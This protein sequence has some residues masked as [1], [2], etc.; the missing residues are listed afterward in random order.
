MTTNDMQYFTGRSGHTSWWRVIKQTTD[1]ALGV[2][3]NK[4]FIVIIK[5]ALPCILVIISTP[6]VSRFSAK[7][8]TPMVFESTHRHHHD[9]SVTYPI[10]RRLFAA[11]EP[12]LARV[13][14][15]LS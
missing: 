13:L 15:S 2:K 10:C 14:A 1:I 5:Y 4:D 9:S 8:T 12:P 6:T 11:E 7:A 3:S